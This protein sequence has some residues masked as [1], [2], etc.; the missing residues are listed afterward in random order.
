MHTVFRDIVYPNS[1]AIGTAFNIV[2]FSTK[3]EVLIIFLIQK[4][5]QG[6]VV[7]SYCKKFVLEVLGTLVLIAKYN[8]VSPSSLN[9]SYT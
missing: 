1:F 4:K 7:Q 8:T 9:T 5:Q 3:S 6:F 2:A